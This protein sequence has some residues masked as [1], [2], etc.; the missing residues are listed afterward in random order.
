MKKFNSAVLIVSGV[1]LMLA[2]VMASW[3]TRARADEP[4]LIK[5]TFFCHTNDD[6]KDHDTG[7]YVVVKN[8]DGT[9]QLLM[10]ITGTILEMMARNTK[11]DQITNSTW[12]STLPD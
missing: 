9:T 6:N 11:M 7:I 12:I 4:V 2:A 5:A 3:A 1:G 10:P 8:Q